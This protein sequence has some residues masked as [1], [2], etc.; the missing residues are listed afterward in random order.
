MTASQIKSIINSQTD[1]T[2]YGFRMT[3]GKE[4]ILAKAYDRR[5][6]TDNTPDEFKP[7][8][9]DIDETNNAIKLVGK[10]ATPMGLQITVLRYVDCDK[11]AEVMFLYDAAE[12]GAL[13]SDNENTPSDGQ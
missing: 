2:I 5:A 13:K 11:I 4:I 6:I 12:D 3:S 10:I 8:E 9:Y 1:D 7:E